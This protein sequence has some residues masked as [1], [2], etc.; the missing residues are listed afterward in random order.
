LLAERLE[1]WVRRQKVA[2]DAL[3]KVQVMYRYFR[4]PG[5]PLK[6]KLLIGAALLYLIIPN[7][8]VPDWLAVVGLSDDFAAITII[9]KQLY[10]V[11][12]KYEERR[13][14]RLAAEEIA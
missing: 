4:D 14:S 3:D 7:D 5:E 9:W 6:P 12:T 2:G 8:L 1:G 11:L 10:D 13:L